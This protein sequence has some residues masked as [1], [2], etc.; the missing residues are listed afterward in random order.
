MGVNP[1]DG[2]NDSHKCAG[3]ADKW[4]ECFVII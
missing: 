3:Y 4:Q 1:N 2:N